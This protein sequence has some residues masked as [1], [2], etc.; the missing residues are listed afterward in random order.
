MRNVLCLLQSS[1]R[2]RIT[3]KENNMSNMV[4]EQGDE[5]PEL[6]TA[7][8]TM[9]LHE[10]IDLHD[11]DHTEIAW[12][13]DAG[14]DFGM[15]DLGITDAQGA[16]DARAGDCYII[17][18]ARELDLECNLKMPVDPYDGRYRVR[19][20]LKAIANQIHINLRNSERVVVNCY[21]G[22]ERSVLSVA[23]YLH[24]YKD[25]TLDEAY[26]HIRKVRPIALD[27]RHWAGV[28]SIEERRIT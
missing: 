27:R 5:T 23:W 2:S 9:T 18:T 6:E 25:M 22:I 13:S 28:K 24:R 1:R 26:D 8:E 17:N 16:V 7:L 15:G 10:W 12:L 20:M 21:M 4:V 14:L 19:H 11:Y 3:H